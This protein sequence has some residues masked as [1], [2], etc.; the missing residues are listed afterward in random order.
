M[1][2]LIS[3]ILLC[4][5]SLNLQ[6]KNVLTMEDITRGS[7]RAQAVYGW[8][9]SKDGESFTQI[10]ADRQRI[11]R[12]SFKTGEEIETVFD[13][14]TARNVKLDYIDGYIMSPA[15]DNILIQTETQSIYRHSY[16]AVFYIYNVRNKTLVPLS[17]NGPQ[18]VPLFSPDGTMVAFVRNNNLF[19]VKLLYNNA[20]SQVTKDG[21]YNEILNG[22][23][24]WVNEEEFGYSR[25]FDFS[26]DSQMLAWIRFDES[27]VPEF[28][29]SLYKGAAPAYTDYALYPGAYSYKYPVAGVDNA[30]VKVMTFDIK[31]RATRTIDLPL[32]ADG[33]IPRIYF[34]KDP[35]KLA[36]MTLNRH[37]NR[38][39][40]YMANPRSCTAQ[41]I[42]RDEAPQ[43]IK[44][45]AYDDIRF[46]DKNFVMM[47]ERDGYNH[48]YLY[49]FNGQLI[50]QITKG[51]FEVTAFYGWD[52]ATNT[53]YYGSNEG[54]PL[55]K[56]V[57]KIDGKGRKTRLTS[58]DG[59]NSALFSANMKYF[60]NNWSDANTPYVFTLND[61]NGKT[62]KTLVDN[63]RLNDKLAQTELGTKEFFTFT[64]SEGVQLNGFMIKPASFDASKKYPVV[65]HQYSG[66]GSQQVTDSWSIG[67]NGNGG[68][69]ESFL[70]SE[71]FICVC[72]D[73][74]GTGG[75]GAEFEKCT[76]L[77][78]GVKESKD[79]VET[80][81]YLGTL[82]YIDK[83]NI[84]IWGWSY[85]GFNTLMSMSEGRP[86][87]KCG[88]AVAPPT[89]W[90]YY[91]TI[92]TE[93]FMR[94]PQENSKGYDECPIS[95]AKNLSGNLLLC[96]GLADDNVHF[97]NSAEY[98][99]SLVQADKQFEMQVYTN[100]NH[101]IGGG[102]TRHHLY[103]RIN[104]F[105]VS[106]L[107]KK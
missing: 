101:G 43:Y 46:Y 107:M 92:Y 99:E 12:N 103:T 61:N 89:S 28:N 53:F 37:Q 4:M 41:L 86:V 34:T 35:D 49:N 52:E 76:Y 31:S 42:V 66:P 6:A 30:K 94:T 58:K 16:T 79:Q 13:V 95:R 7:F 82:P 77:N 33:Y 87:F 57:Y 78:L 47:S 80:A 56:N 32:E 93:R 25:A 54:S 75:R 19:L 68:L 98:S 18:Q 44:E 45:P 105:F 17:E 10:S 1:K 59:T 51:E 84:A 71:G 72:V 21:K 100:R 26:A 90:R 9:P 81:I 102:N 48:L 5:F 27:Q 55:R 91:D 39:D 73:G 14:N 62:L 36:V 29:F 60:L 2:K 63:Q 38:Y 104:N 23:P 74:R 24:D 20:E 69:F 67:A 83:N 11:V 40:I 8:T 64:T 96:H 15:E 50:K 22:I 70:C 106:N 3:L 85:G 65:M 88:V 97:R